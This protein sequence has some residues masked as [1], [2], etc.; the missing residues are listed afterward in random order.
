LAEPRPPANEKKSQ[1]RVLSLFPVFPERTPE[2]LSHSCIQF[3]RGS[4]QNRWVAVE[5]GARGAGD[6]DGEDL[7]DVAGS[8]LENNNLV[9]AGAA[10]ES[11]EERVSP[12]YRHIFEF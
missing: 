9:R 10:R 8:T 1:S 7:A 5:R 6:F 12:T 3:L 4:F 11:L 2:S